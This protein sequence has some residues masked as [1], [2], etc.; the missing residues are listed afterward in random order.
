[1]IDE[2]WVHPQSFVGILSENINV[3]SEE[4]RV[5][6]EFFGQALFRSVKSTHTRYFP[7][8]FFTTTVLAN[9]SR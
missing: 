6:K 3:R 9:H 1:M 2:A 8:F 5:G 7:N 4:R